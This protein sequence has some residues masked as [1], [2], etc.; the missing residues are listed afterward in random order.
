MHTKCTKCIH[1]Y[2]YIGRL[3]LNPSGARH[4]RPVLFSLLKVPCA[5]KRFDSTCEFPIIQLMKR[6]ELVQT[7]SGSLTS[8]SNVGEA[9]LVALVVSGSDLPL[10]GAT[11]SS[12]GVRLT[13]RVNPIGHC[14]GGLTRVTDRSNRP[15]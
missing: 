12:G 4:R 5:P 10:R 2:I 1:T 13:L 6:I 14:S 11:C 7:R 8:W 3:A 9:T 15:A